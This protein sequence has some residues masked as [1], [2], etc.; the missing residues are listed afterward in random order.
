MISLIDIRVARGEEGESGNSDL[1][2]CSYKLAF[3][4]DSR[5]LHLKVASHNLTQMN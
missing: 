2:T 3:N 1:V 5:F 4:G